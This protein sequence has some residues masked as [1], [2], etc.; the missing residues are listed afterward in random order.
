LKVAYS[1]ESGTG[2]NKQLITVVTAILLNMDSQWPPVE[3]ELSALKA[4][5]PRELLRGSGKFLSLF[6]YGRDRELKGDLLF[7]G[8]RGKMHGVA[9]QKA[10]ESLMQVLSV[11]VKN[12]VQIFHGAIDRTGRSE[13]NREHGVSESLQTDQEA[14]FD[15][16][17]RRLDGFVHIYMPKERVLWIADKS[18]FEAS[19]KHGL[20]FFQWVQGI[21]TDTLTQM[22]SALRGERSGADLNLSVCDDRPSHVIDTIYFGDS[23]ESLALQLADVCCT[24]IAQH[25]QGRQDAEPFYN[26][27]RRQ[28]VTDGTLVVYSNAWMERVM[29]TRSVNSCAFHAC[30]ATQRPCRPLPSS[31]SHSA[32][33]QRSHR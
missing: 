27:I 10:A 32:H 28:V 15:E 1:D 24:T 4:L 5:M 33:A 2:D 6:I 23:H 18:G 16:C 20:K 8:L 22:L 26:L 12:D 14:A 7:K 11:A 31:G 29:P 3:R 19:V 17:L 25:L 21:D 9:R 30:A 13:W